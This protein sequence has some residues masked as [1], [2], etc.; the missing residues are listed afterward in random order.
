MDVVYTSAAI[1]NVNFNNNYLDRI[2]INI[3]GGYKYYN[4]KRYDDGFTGSFLNSSI[5]SDTNV[6]INVLYRYAITPFNAID[7]SGLTYI[8][9]NAYIYPVIYNINID[10]NSDQLIITNNSITFQNIT[11]VYFYYDLNRDNYAVET[12]INKN[13]VNNI[14]YID[15]GLSS[16]T[17]YNYQLIPYNALILPG[18]PYNLR[19]SKNRHLHTPAAR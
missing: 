4:I 8:T 9:E 3:I 15:S 6:G 13:Y 16:N 12:E 11:G 19:L 18:N 1:T 10:Q 2:V 17:F 7:I 14:S 5:I